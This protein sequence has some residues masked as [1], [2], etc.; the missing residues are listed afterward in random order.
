MKQS[1]DMSFT[2]PKFSYCCP[3]IF[4]NDLTLALFLENV[5]WAFSPCVVQ[6]IANESVAHRPIYK[7]STKTECKHLEIL[8]TVFNRALT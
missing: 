2:F 4:K 7:I 1:K 6:S 3:F 5:F 8:T